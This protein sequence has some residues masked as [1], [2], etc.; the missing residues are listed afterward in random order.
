MC[1][2]LGTLA[3]TALPSWTLRL[4]WISLQ[5]RQQAFPLGVGAAGGQ[6]LGAVAGVGHALARQPARCRGWWPSLKTGRPL[7][8]GGKLKKGLAAKWHR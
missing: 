4:T 1:Q 5:M 7:S 3:S 2:P 6:A 8:T